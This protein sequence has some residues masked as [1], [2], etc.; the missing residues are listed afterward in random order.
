MQIT[1]WRGRIV[2]EIYNLSW[3]PWI[4]YDEEAFKSETG[5]MVRGFN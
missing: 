2:P 4:L 3:E 1:M 5:M